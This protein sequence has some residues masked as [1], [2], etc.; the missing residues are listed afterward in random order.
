[1]REIGGRPRFYTLALLHVVCFALFYVALWRGLPDSASQGARSLLALKL[2]LEILASFSFITVILKSIDY[3]LAPAPE[4]MPLRAEGEDGG[5]PPPIAAI[6]LCA[7]DLDPV[8]LESLCL[9]DYPGRYHVFVHDDSGDAEVAERVDDLA[10]DLATRTGRPIFVLRRP[11]REGG[12]P[13]AVNYVL[14]RLSGRYPFVLLADNDSTAVDPRALRAALPLLEDP[15]VAAVQFRNVAV[16]LENEGR[17]GALL[18]RAI[19]VFDLFARHQARHGMPLFFG[20]NALLRAAAIHDAGGMSEGVFADDIDLS[21]RLVRRGWR[22]LYA[23]WI[24]FGETHPA[25]YAAFRRRA[26]KWSYGCGQILRRHLV[27]ALLDPRLGMREKAGLVEF[28]GF[29]AVQAVLIA[30]LALVGLVLPIVSGPVPGQEPALFLSGA[31]VVASIFLPAFAYHARRG[32]TG[33]WWPFALVCAIVYG[34]VAFCSTRGLLDGALGRRRRWVPTNVAAGVRGLAPA[35]ACE[36]LFGL[37]LVL[38]PAL[39]CPSALWQPSLH[40]F[41]AVFLLT[42]FA[43]QLYAPD[44]RGGAARGATDSFARRPAPALRTRA[45]ILGVALL[46]SGLA[47]YGIPLLHARGE[48]N[49][50]VGIEGDRFVVDG[51][52]FLVQGIHYSP[53]RPGTGPMKGYAWP[54]DTSIERDLGMI[55]TTGANT[56]LVH[57]APASI[58]PLAGRHGLMVIATYFINWQSI[59]DEVAF[60]ARAAEIVAAARAIAPQPN[61]LAILLGNEVTEWVLKERGAP[62]IEARLRGLYREVKAAAPRVPVSHANWPVTR[63][64]DLSFLDFTAFNLYPAWP[65]E[66]AVAGYGPY[67]ESVLKPIAAGRPLLISEF[68]QNSLEATEARQAQVMRDCWAE[69]RT[70]AAGGVVFAFADEWW[71]NYDNPIDSSDYWQ[72]RYAP[73]DEK[74]HDLDPEE[75][76][77]IVTAEREP[78]PAYGAVSEMFTPRSSPALRAALYALPLVLLMTYTLYVMIRGRGE[79]PAVSGTSVGLVARRRPGAGAG[80]REG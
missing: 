39:C 64:L 15:R 6:Y 37:S 59:G 30:Y 28:I 9:L 49:R 13:G 61:L 46:L 24:R 58:L 74:T 70:R 69:I 66:V 16:P 14:S 33:E 55:R 47:V 20:H 31:A 40:L 38:V 21:I 51:R 4:A 44:R 41:A 76:Y 54:D 23:P 18:R 8:A 1:V 25:S 5:P 65:R 56:I 3:L 45:V 7:G 71:K 2:G 42:P 43:A 50:R 63:S 10:G 19:E 80:R 35:Y 60:R 72:R 26:S 68:G 27:P 17:V 36:A 75:Y 32:R 52:T 12:K 29:Y 73:D 34:S 79:D 53:W 62:L 78:K 11:G 67:I 77:G 22:I 57:D 48:E